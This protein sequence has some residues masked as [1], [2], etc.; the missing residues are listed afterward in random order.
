MALIGWLSF[1]LCYTPPTWCCFLSNCCCCLY[2]YVPLLTISWQGLYYMLLCTAS[3]YTMTGIILESILSNLKHLTFNGRILEV[4]NCATGWCLLLKAAFPR[5]IP[6]HQSLIA[7]PVQSRRT[8]IKTF[9]CLSV[10]QDINWRG[11]RKHSHCHVTSVHAF[12]MHVYLLLTPT[13]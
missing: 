3:H 2:T 11:E 12:Y 7:K 6:A 8:L 1:W 4:I 9:D 10:S 13:V 5:Y